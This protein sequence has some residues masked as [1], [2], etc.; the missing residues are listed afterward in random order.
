MTA[1]LLSV[2]DLSVEFRTPAGRIRA[3]DRVSFDLHKG[4]TLALVGESGCGKSTLAR[5]IVGLVP[6][7]GGSVSYAG[8]EITGKSRALLR[9][10]RQKLQL[11]FQDPYA[12]LNP[13]LTISAILEEPLLLHQRLSGKPADDRVSELL[14]QV[15]L[16]PSLR[17][18]YPHEFSGGQRQRISVARAL[19]VGPEMLLCDEVTS[20]LDVS[21][22]AQ[23]LELLAGLQARLGLSYL[24]ITHDLGV[25]R[26]IAQRIAVMYLGQLVE[27]SATE[28]FF[29]QPLHP[30]SH[31][32]LAS[33][34]RLQVQQGRT[35]ALMQGEVPSPARPPS[36]CRFH[37]RCPRRFERCP[38]EEPPTYPVADRLSRCFLHDPATKP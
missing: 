3:V 12:S 34:P 38:R 26:S 2:R 16:D 8:R 37:T 31:G 30:Y 1:P 11:V 23:M 13:R 14:E 10:V 29:E 32:L 25:V 5:A 6:V 4:E 22:Q 19:A 15:G 20:A 18:R 27:L 33:I 28:E 21:V 35:R 24:F 17:T 9:P 7:S 36:G